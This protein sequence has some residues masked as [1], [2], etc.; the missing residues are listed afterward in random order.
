[1]TRGPRGCRTPTQ[2]YRRFAHSMR[3]RP[4]PHDSAN[5]NPLQTFPRRVQAPPSILGG[6]GA[7]NLCGEVCFRGGQGATHYCGG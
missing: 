4:A 3:A 2:A 6:G 7:T 1:M 5:T